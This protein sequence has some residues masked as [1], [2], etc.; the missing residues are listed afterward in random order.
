MKTASNYFIEF[1]KKKIHLKDNVF[2]PNL[3]SKLSYETAKENL[4]KKTKVLDL[5]CGSGI[6][7]ILIKKNNDKV[8]LFCSDNHLKAIKL[9]KKNLIK[10]KVFGVV[11]KGSLFEPWRGFKFDYIIDDVSAIS[12]SIAA[13][14]IW[15]K[16]K[17]PASCGVDGTDLTIKVIKNAKKFLNKGG[18]LQ[19]PLLSLSNTDRVKKE[20]KKI[21]SKTKIFK[22]EKWFL[23]DNLAKQKKLLK[24]LKEKKRINYEE[25][26]GKII[27]ET[28]IMICEN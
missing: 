23:P 21:F 9:T 17:I 28:S 27:C 20:A 14:S 13:K 12:S 25:K 1:I 18:I 3:T 5:G 4:S 26:F 19:L 11:K 24:K 16:K 7:G 6:I 10:N 8:H 2:Q 22:S 15:F